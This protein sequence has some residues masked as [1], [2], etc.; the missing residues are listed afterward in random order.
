MDTDAICAG[1]LMC[2]LHLARLYVSVVCG[3]VKANKDTVA[4]QPS[5]ATAKVAEF[6]NSYAG[7]RCLALTYLH[8]HSAHQTGIETCCRLRQTK[9][10][11]LA[12]TIVGTTGGSRRG[13]CSRPGADTRHHQDPAAL[14]R[15]LAKVNP[16]P[17]LPYRKLC[18]HHLNHGSD[19]L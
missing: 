10:K 16:A 18:N 4:N 15:L 19:R 8:C 3:C 9:R 11:P 6:N 1:L 13:F 12:L 2:P 5:P 17:A 7:S 14:P